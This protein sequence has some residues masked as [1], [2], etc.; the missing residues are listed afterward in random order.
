MYVLPHEH[1]SSKTI[2]S[3]VVAMTFD[4]LLFEL[5]VSSLPQPLI[6]VFA[7]NL[8]S[9]LSMPIRSRPYIGGHSFS[10]TSMR[11]AVYRLHDHLTVLLTHVSVPTTT[12]EK[13]STNYHDCAKSFFRTMEAMLTTDITNYRN[14][15]HFKLESGWFYKRD[16]INSPKFLTA[17]Q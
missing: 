5:P 17:P 8:C 10:Q 13:H 6:D 15:P 11:S 12:S 3:T 9:V 7:P 2:V 16:H 1:R 14:C 4:I